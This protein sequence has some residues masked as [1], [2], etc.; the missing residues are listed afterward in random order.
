[1]IHDYN[2]TMFGPVTTTK[3]LS[4]EAYYSIINSRRWYE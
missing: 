1:M 4:E 2:L 3:L